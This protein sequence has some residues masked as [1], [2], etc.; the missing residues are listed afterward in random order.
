[1][2]SLIKNQLEQIITNQQIEDATL[3][4]VAGK[5]EQTTQALGALRV[6]LNELFQLAKPDDYKFAWIVN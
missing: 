2:P 4:I 3:L 5:Y 6:K 1:M